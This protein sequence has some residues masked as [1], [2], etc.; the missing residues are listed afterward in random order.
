MKYRS[1]DVPREPFLSLAQALARSTGKTNAHDAPT[2]HEMEKSPGQAKLRGHMIWVLS[3]FSAAVI[4]A[5]RD[6]FHTTGVMTVAKLL[7]PLAECRGGVDDATRKVMMR[8]RR[9]RSE[10]TLLK[11]IFRVDHITRSPTLNPCLALKELCVILRV[12]FGWRLPTFL[13]I[14]SA[15]KKDASREHVSPSF[16]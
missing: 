6:N 2:N 9:L 11:R 3:L 8:L 12:S 13:I 5:R 7:I 10:R 16:V 1:P 4:R 14:S 15:V